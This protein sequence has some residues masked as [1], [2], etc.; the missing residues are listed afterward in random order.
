VRIDPNVH[1][2]S[3]RIEVYVICDYET[4]TH[5]K[6]KRLYIAACL[7]VTSWLLPRHDH[8]RDAE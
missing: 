1:L 4:R 5:E 7:P 3:A 6:A 8:S 2:S